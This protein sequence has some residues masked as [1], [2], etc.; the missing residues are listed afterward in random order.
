MLSDLATESGIEAELDG[1]AYTQKIETPI[2]EPTGEQ[3]SVSELYDTSVTDLLLTDIDAADLPKDL[4]S[5]LVVAAKRHTVLRFDKIANYYAHADSNLQRL[6]EASALVVVD[7]DQAV[8][9]GFLKL[10]ESMLDALDS[11]YPD[12]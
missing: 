11:E 10:H 12:A 7:S 5:F 8:E 9:R 6:M 4:K 2:Y 1:V 3:P